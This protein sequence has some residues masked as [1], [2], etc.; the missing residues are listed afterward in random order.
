MTSDEELTLKAL[1]SENGP[2]PIAL[3]ARTRHQTRGKYCGTEAP[4]VRNVTVRLESM[5]DFVKSESEDFSYQ[6]RSTAGVAPLQL[7]RIWSVR[8]TVESR[9]GVRSW[10]TS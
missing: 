7:K 5:L 4:I 3:C 1:T 2:Q 9:A 10:T 8:C 6:Y